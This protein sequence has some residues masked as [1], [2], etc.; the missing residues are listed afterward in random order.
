MRVRSEKRRELLQTLV[1]LMAPLRAEPGCDS[2][3]F[4]TDGE[5]PAAFQV[6]SEWQDRE[7]FEQHLASPTFRV[8]RGSRLLLSEEP[9]AHFDLISQR[10]VLATD[11][12]WT[13]N[14]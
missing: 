4:Y 10:T 13:C 9:Q 8:F 2:Y 1:A 11:K 14:P 5:D 6:I 12:G 7:L 3:H